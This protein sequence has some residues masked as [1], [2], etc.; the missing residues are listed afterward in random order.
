M[1][2]EAARTR[3]YNNLHELRISVI[4]DTFKKLDMGWY[5]S[6]TGKRVSFEEGVHDVEANTKSVVKYD[7]DVNEGE[8]LPPMSER[9]YKVTEVYVRDADCVV[10]A[11]K[12]VDEGMRVAVINM[13][14][15]SSP[16]GGYLHGA[17]AQEENLF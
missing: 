9:P 1:F 13:A 12:M 10:E 5:T 11:I 8:K 2:K 3:D 17:G 6:S 16:G 4:L 7:F 15:E 14:N